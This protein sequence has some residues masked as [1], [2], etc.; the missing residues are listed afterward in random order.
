MQIKKFMKEKA[1]LIALFLMLITGPML[2]MTACKSTVN[3]SSPGIATA[4]STFTPTIT[5]TKTPVPTATANTAVVPY[6]PGTIAFTAFIR[7]GNSQFAFV[8]TSGSAVTAGTTL[9]FT[10]LCFD[11]SAGTAGQFVDNSG[12]VGASPVTEGTVAYTVGTGGLNPFVPVVIGGVGTWLANTGDTV[13]VVSDGSSNLSA[14][15]LSINPPAL[16][17]NHNN[18]LGDKL[19]CYM[20]SQAATV[21]GPLPANFGF[22]TALYYGPYNS[23][24]SGWDVSGTSIG[25]SSI[26]TCLPS[27]LSASNSLDLSALWQN[28]ALISG[29]TTGNQNAVLG[30][31]SP[32]TCQNTLAG[33]YTGSNWSGDVL[34]ASHMAVNLLTATSYGPAVTPTT[35]NL[36]W[37]G[38]GATTGVG[39]TVTFTVVQQATQIAY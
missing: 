9:Y 24:S 14:L 31:E 13:S 33:I 26:N 32:F 17:F 38:G 23:G 3:P 21:G 11:T 7:N 25:T 6:S 1:S 15:S 28:S 12:T 8:N 37:C 35:A 19:Y 2:T 5:S 36:T 27:T 29:S 10:N 18:E 4:T 34:S 16:V 22:I 39:Y 20:A 30:T